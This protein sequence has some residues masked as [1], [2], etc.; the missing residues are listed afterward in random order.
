MYFFLKK[1][2]QQFKKNGIVFLYKKVRIILE[3]ISYI[4]LCIIFFPIIVLIRIISPFFIVRFGILNSSRIG[5]LAANTELYLCKKDKKINVPNKPYF[6]IFYLEHSYY[7]N[8]YLI[9]K[10]KEILYVLPRWIIHPLNILNN[11]LPYG[12]IHKIGT[13]IKSDRDNY[14]LLDKCKPHLKITAHEEQIGM[15][16]LRDMG[17]PKYAQIVC[18]FVR[19]SSYLKSYIPDGNWDYH[20]YRDNNIENFIPASEYLA[21]KGF[22][23]LRMGRIVEKPIVSEKLKIIDYASSKFA[24]DFMDIYLGSK[25]TFCISTGAGWDAVP[26]FIFRKPTIFTNLVPFGYLPTFSNKFLLT[27]KRHFSK[28]LNKELTVSEIFSYGLYDCLQTSSY[29][30]KKI[31]L[32]ENTSDEIK[33]VVIEMIEFLN[34]KIISNEFDKKITNCF[35]KLYSELNYIYSKKLRLHGELK[36]KFSISYLKNNSEWI[37]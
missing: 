33:N 9:K 34:G 19:D 7:C 8:R 14:N 28:K 3:I 11:I 25:C 32:I 17:I 5:H 24:S 2:F 35:W 1:Q 13:N 22:Y 20:S 15:S 18:L 4:L 12:D 37:N 36:S 21:D 10:W 31:I 27:T 6:D 30:E 29:N 23:V 16:I 26:S